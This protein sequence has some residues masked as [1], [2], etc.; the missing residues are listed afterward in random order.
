M[1]AIL[2]SRIYLAS[3]F[4]VSSLFA[5]FQLPAADLETVSVSYTQI[6]RIYRLNG[7]VEAV[8]KTTV[9]AQ[10]S[11]QVEA[12]LFDVDDY[13]EKDQVIILINDKQ[14]AARLEQAKAEIEE[15]GARVKEADEEYQR[16][17]GVY[18]KQAVS[19]KTMDA[20][21]AAMKAARA[22]LKSARAG[23]EQAREQFDYTRVRA[24]YSGIVTERHIEVGESAEAGKKLMSGLSL[25]ELR[26][27]VDVP[28]N[29]IN[30]V[31]TA[32]EV[33]IE[34]PK[35]NRVPVTNKTV[36]PFADPASHTFRVR[37]ELKGDNLSLFPG[38]FVKA[39]F[40]TGEQGALIVP[41][42]SIVRRSEVTAVYV[43]SAD[44]R[45]SMRAIR[46]GRE[47]DNGYTVVLAGL[48]QG[49]T[50]IVDPIIAGAQLQQQYSSEPAR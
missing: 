37:L 9:S 44:G 5:C 50:V 31:R 8:N 18:E 20:A 4:A 3:C 38:M 34:T 7:V 17:K 24:P 1:F 21:E 49:E 22:R 45:L 43:A 40:T 47:L 13:V 33:A 12:M 26:V 32:A 27:N 10:I 29:M 41:S 48:Q 36:F 6:P 14:P 39:A 15:A 28:Q 2:R 11:G 16:I 42:A 25:E 30:A 19:K 35:G 23:L 46:K